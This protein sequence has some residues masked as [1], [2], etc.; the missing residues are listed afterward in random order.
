MRTEYGGT[1][2]VLYWKNNDDETWGLVKRSVRILLEKSLENIHFPHN[3]IALGFSFCYG[4]TFGLILFSSKNQRE[5][6][7]LILV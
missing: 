6:V 4:L 7:G 1:R 2:A 3:L 5:P